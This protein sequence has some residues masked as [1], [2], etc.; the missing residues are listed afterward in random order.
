MFDLVHWSTKTF[1]TAVKRLNRGALL[2]SEH[3][4][5]VVRIWLQ[6]LVFSECPSGTGPRRSVVPTSWIVSAATCVFVSVRALRNETR[7]SSS[8]SHDSTQSFWNFVVAERIGT[9]S[10]Q[11]TGHISTSTT[12]TLHSVDMEKPVEQHG[13]VSGCRTHEVLE[14][15][16]NNCLRLTS[17]GRPRSRWW[18]WWGWWLEKPRLV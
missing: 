16:R 2:V 7:S 1:F 4:G 10:W 6:H 15:S 12:N 9:C 13:H 5:M 11:N 8:A 18:R 17:P 3:A 14:I